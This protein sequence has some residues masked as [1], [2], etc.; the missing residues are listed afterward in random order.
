MDDDDYDYNDDDADYTDDDV[1]DDDD[2]DRGCV[3]GGTTQML[4]TRV[5]A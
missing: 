4:D 1:N 5:Y 3:G 2:A